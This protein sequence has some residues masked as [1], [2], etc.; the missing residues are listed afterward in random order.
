MAPAESYLDVTT[1][2]F[3]LSLLHNYTEWESREPS[4]NYHGHNTYAYLVAKYAKTC[5]EGEEV[6]TFDH[7]SI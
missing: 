4:F 5:V 3:D 7:I 1:S 2:A 6:N